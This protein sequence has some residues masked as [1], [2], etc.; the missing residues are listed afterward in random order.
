MGYAPEANTSFYMGGTERSTTVCPTNNPHWTLQLRDPNDVIVGTSSCVV[1]YTT[2]VSSVGVCTVVGLT[3]PAIAAWTHW[4]AS[5]QRQ[6]QFLFQVS[7]QILDEVARLKDG[8][9]GS[10]GKRPSEPTVAT[11]QQLLPLIPMD[12]VVPDV[13]VDGGEGLISLRWYSH[14]NSSVVSLAALED[15][16]TGVLSA[17]DLPSFGWELAITKERELAKAIETLLISTHA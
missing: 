8:W 17:R 5:R 1:G 9:D 6:R 2:L 7:G 14:D 15:K 13:E 10:G 11:L 3:N 16:V 4:T 12:A